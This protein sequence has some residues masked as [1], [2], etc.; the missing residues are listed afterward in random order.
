MQALFSNLQRDFQ[1]TSVYF[2]SSCAR[3]KSIPT[4]TIRSCSA[5]ISRRTSAAVRGH[6]KRPFSNRFIHRQNPVRSQ[7]TAFSSCRCALQ[8]TNS[9]VSNALDLRHLLPCRP[10]PVPPAPDF[11]ALLLPPACLSNLASTSTTVRAPRNTPS[12]T[13]RFAATL[14]CAGSNSRDPFSSLV[15]PARN[16]ARL[17]HRQRHELTHD[18]IDKSPGK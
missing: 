17:R 18:G 3:Q 6:G 13:A 11:P 1:A 8:N 10:V 14:L 7:Y 9:A 4:S 2:S 5:L 12:W 16:G 15:P